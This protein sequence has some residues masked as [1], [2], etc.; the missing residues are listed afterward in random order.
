MN[1]DKGYARVYGGCPVNWPAAGPV[2]L[3]HRHPA[4]RIRTIRDAGC[5]RDP[6]DLLGRCTPAALDDILDDFVVVTDD[7]S[8]RLISTGTDVSIFGIIA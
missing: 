8:G 3:L 2:R 6:T 7:N 4:P 1:G 5:G